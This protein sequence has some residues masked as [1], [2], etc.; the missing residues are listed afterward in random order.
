MTQ[1]NPA[2]KRTNANIPSIHTHTGPEAGLGS[3]GM[4]KAPARKY[5]KLMPRAKYRKLN[6][7]LLQHFSNRI[8]ATICNAVKKNLSTNSLHFT[9]K[10]VHGAPNLESLCHNNTMKSV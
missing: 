1:D 3:F 9:P 6:A 10:Y 5:K 2:K 4:I 7:F 8:P